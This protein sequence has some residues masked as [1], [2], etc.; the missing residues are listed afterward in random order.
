MSRLPQAPE[1]RGRSAEN[2]APDARVPPANCGL[3]GPG[4]CT[5]SGFWGRQR[6]PACPVLGGRGAYPSLRSGAP[7]RVCARVSV[8]TCPPHRLATAPGLSVA[9]RPLKFSPTSPFLLKRSRP[10]APCIG[11]M[12]PSPPA[13]ASRPSRYCAGLWLGALAGPQDFLSGGGRGRD[14]TREGLREAR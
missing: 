13:S 5:L 8:S 6:R 1:H 3:C 4:A 12:A 9:G 10:G 11:S 7:V 14:Q 2:C